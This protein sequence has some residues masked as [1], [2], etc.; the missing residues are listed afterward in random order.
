MA[1]VPSPAPCL[2]AAGAVVFDTGGVITD[3]ARSRAAAWK[4]AFDARLTVALPGPAS[5]AFEIRGTH[6]IPRSRGR[7]PGHTSTAAPDRGTALAPPG[8]APGPGWSHPPDRPRHRAMARSTGGRTSRPPAQARPSGLRPPE[9]T[10]WSTW[11][12]RPCR[13]PG[14]ALPG[15]GSSPCPGMV[16]SSGRR[17]PAAAGTPLT[18]AR[19]R[20]LRRTGSSAPTSC[21]C[22]RGSSAWERTRH[23]AHR[24]GPR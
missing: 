6:P 18:G 24:A 10:T 16:V 23:P 4:Q 2:R 8:R 3:S 14:R 9:S 13:G 1:A 20:W 19:P 7:G 21:C 12:S 22:R 5:P 17:R 11:R 15:T